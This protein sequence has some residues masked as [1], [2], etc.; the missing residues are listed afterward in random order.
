MT[1]QQ[2]RRWF[3][4]IVAAA[5]VWR[6]L[7][8][9]VFKV[10][11]GVVGDQIYYSAQ[12]V[13]IA[14]GQGFADPFM[15]GA[16]AADHA[17]LTSLA[18]APVSWDNAE[19]FVAQ[20]LLMAMYGVVVVAGI[21]AVVRW[22]SDRVTSLVATGF[23]AVYANLWMNDGL[24]MAETPA[25]LGVVAV[26]FAAYRLDLSRTQRDAA[27]LGLAVGLAGL[28]RAEL[29]LLGVLV[30]APIALRPGPSA[31]PD[32]TWRRRTGHLGVAALAAIAMVSPWIIRNQIR[33]DETVTMS[34][35]DGLTLVGTNCPA[36]FEGPGRGFWH[37]SC[38]YDVP[39]PVDADQSVRSV[40]YRDAAFEYLGNHVD[41]LPSVIVARLGRGFSVWQVDSMNVLNQGE[42]RERLASQI[43]VLQFWILAALAIYGLIRWPIRQTRWPII[44]LVIM[45][46]LTIAALYGIPRFRI[47]A[48]VG[49]VVA[50]AIGAVDLTRRSRR[51]AQPGVVS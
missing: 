32:V 31:S 24:I 16:Y 29:L 47:A 37:L 40:I 6:V 11:D 41:L 38:A 22:L 26:L 35:Q 42:G 10:D 15:P 43:G 33:F 7:Y 2:Y 28:A 18:V 36:A 27:L 5:A 48:E 46:V 12:A 34:T 25:A 19:P 44:G 51:S 13:T 1:K 9:L 21:G 50:A 8:V 30:V 39:V 23:A 49:I 14:N 3:A 45:S 20:R 4:G 17:P